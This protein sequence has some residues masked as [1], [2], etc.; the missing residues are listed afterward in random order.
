MRP[1]NTIQIII[2]RDLGRV[3]M[4]KKH[5]KSI[6]NPTDI[7]T[8]FPETNGRILYKHATPYNISNF[9]VYKAATHCSQ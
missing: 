3:K 4:E 9:K 8:V 6:R 7:S 2:K 1:L 5:I